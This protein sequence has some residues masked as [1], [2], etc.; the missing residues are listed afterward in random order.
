[1]IFTEQLRHAQQQYDAWRKQQS[2][3]PQAVDRDFDNATQA[4]QPVAR[5]R[6]KNRT[7]K[8]NDA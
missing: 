1:M 2:A 8:D 4:L 7:P 5:K 3:L 6:G